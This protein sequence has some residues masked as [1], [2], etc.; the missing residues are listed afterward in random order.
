VYLHEIL[1]SKQEKVEAA[2]SG[3]ISNS[4]MNIPQRNRI[5]EKEKWKPN[6]FQK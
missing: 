1:G 2:N 5:L 3:H 4:G 6:C